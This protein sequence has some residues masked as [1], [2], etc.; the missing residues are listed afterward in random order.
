MILLKSDVRQTMIEGATVR[1]L[2]DTHLFKLNGMI[3]LQHCHTPMH[4]GLSKKLQKYTL[5]TTVSRCDISLYLKIHFQDQTFSAITYT[6]LILS[7]NNV[8]SQRIHPAERTKE[9]RTV[10]A[11]TI[12]VDSTLETTPPT[13]FLDHDSRSGSEH[14]MYYLN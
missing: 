5:L 4:N 11:K 12:R 1:Y 2:A 9:T 6:L 10:G 8:E 14:F 3:K 13:L 7:I